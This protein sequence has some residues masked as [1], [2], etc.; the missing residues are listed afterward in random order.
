[1]VLVVE[2]VGASHWK[3]SNWLVSLLMMSC[4]LLEPGLTLDRTGVDVRREE[5]WI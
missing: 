5:E 1:V 2:L 3:E 4:R